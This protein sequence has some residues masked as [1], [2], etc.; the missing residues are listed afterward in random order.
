MVTLCENIE[1][2]TTN[3]GCLQQQLKSA[4]SVR[5]SCPHINRSS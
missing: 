1:K 2:K 4:F 5:Y 3:F